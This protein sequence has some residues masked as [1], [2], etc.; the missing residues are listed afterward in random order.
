MITPCVAGGTEKYEG[1]TLY[2]WKLSPGK[3]FLI[4]DE[5]K[6]NEGVELTPTMIK[7]ARYLFE[8]RFIAGKTVATFAIGDQVY[9]QPLPTDGPTRKAAERPSTPRAQRRQAEGK[10][11]PT[12]EEPPQ[13]GRRAKCLDPL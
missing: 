13:R 11:A 10:H 4:N 1:R 8:L 3:A 7:Q 5:T 2:V 6:E 12:P 9:G